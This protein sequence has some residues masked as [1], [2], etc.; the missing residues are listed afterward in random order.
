MKNLE[1]SEILNSISYNMSDFETKGSKRVKFWIWKILMEQIL[2]NQISLCVQNWSKTINNVPDLDWGLHNVSDFELKKNRSVRFLVREICKTSLFDFK[3]LERVRIW[4]VYFLQRVI[5][6][7]K[8]FSM[9]V[10]DLAKKMVRLWDEKLR[11]RRDFEFNVLQY[12]R[13][14]TEKLTVCQILDIK[15]ITVTDFDNTKAFNYV[16]FWSKAFHNV[17]DSKWGLHTVSYLQLKTIEQCHF[18]RRNLW[19]VS[20]WF[21]TFRRWETLR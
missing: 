17:S 7:K 20:F 14:L 4:K 2:K 11:L 9:P 3:L 10:F 5:I 12:F 16:N 15:S 8:F 1:F 19:P 18:G 13:F 21:Q 6:W